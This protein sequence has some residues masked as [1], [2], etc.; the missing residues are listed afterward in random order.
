[1]FEATSVTVFKNDPDQ[2]EVKVKEFNILELVPASRPS[3]SAEQ[4][5]RGLFASEVRTYMDARPAGSSCEITFAVYVCT[6]EVALLKAG[7]LRLCSIG[8]L[9]DT[10]RN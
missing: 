2:F 3:S 10:V 9:N 7:G 1:M 8:I 6:V 4:Q 5:E